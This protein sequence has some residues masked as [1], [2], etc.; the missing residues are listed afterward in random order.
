MRTVAFCEVEPFCRAVL[1]KHWPDVPILG[2]VRNAWFP[3]ADV[4]SGGFPCQDISRAGKRAGLAGT[5]SGLWR[6]FLRAIC[7]VRPLYAIVENVAALL[8]RGLGDVLGDLAECRY[9]A[10][11]NCLQASDV[12]LPHARERIWIVAHRD[13]LRKLQPRW[14]LTDERRW[15]GDEDQAIDW[16]LSRGGILRSHDGIPAGL[17]RIGPLGNAVVPQIPEIIGRPI[18]NAVTPTHREQQQYQR[19][20]QS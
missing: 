13:G 15:V 12:G 7:M 16:V 5:N 8:G 10:E 4:I 11:W 6:E 1:K 19:Q 20:S 9:D 3:A 14:G 18:M 17:D 2:D